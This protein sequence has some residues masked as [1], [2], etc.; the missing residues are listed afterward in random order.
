MVPLNISDSDIPSLQGK[1]AIITGGSSGIGLAAVK[2]LTR[3]GATVHVLD[4][5]PP[6]DDDALPDGVHFQRCNIA[7]WAELRD[8]FDSVSGPIDFA[9][10][11]AGVSEEADYFADTHDDDG[12]LAE[13]A[14]RVL[15][16]NV[17]GVYN[18]VKLSLSR[19][20]KEKTPGSIVITTSASGYAPEQSLPVYSSG[21]LAVSKNQRT[22]PTSHAPLSPWPYEIK[23]DP[24][25]KHSIWE[26]KGG[27]SREQAP[28]SCEDRGACSG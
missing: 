26:G 28:P 17:R 8:A 12:R 9:F 4:I 22:H 2:L 15:E 11:N 7:I 24:I 10:A 13:P 19:M 16:V 27:E 25:N 14:Y 6:S 20:R 3:K 18:F 1:T 23:S 21:K 5:N